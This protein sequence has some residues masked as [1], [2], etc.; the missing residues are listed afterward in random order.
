M[1]GLGPDH[2]YYLKDG[3]D[4]TYK[5]VANL[6]RTYWHD[7]ESGRQPQATDTA[8]KILK[9]E[10]ALAAHGTRWSIA[11]PSRLIR[12]HYQL[13]KLAPDI[14]WSRRMRPV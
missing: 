12:I 7:A 8:E 2:D 9:L 4:G 10:T 3:E 13:N 11:I 14:D 5:K 1:T 6:S